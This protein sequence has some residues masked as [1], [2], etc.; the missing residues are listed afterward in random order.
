MFDLLRQKSFCQHHHHFKLAIILDLMVLTMMAVVMEVVMVIRVVAI[1][2]VFVFVVVVF[3][4]CNDSHGNQDLTTE[5]SLPC[6]RCR[7][8]P[9]SEKDSKISFF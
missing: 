7:R 6:T 3:M 5:T 9:H 4:V 1:V 2:V 8:K